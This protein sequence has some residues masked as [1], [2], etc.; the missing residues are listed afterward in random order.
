MII[1]QELHNRVM[2]KVSATVSKYFGPTFDL[3]IPVSYRSDMKGTAGI[4]YV[5]SKK[6]ELNAQLFLANTEKFFERTIPHEVAHIITKMV[7]PHAKQSHG[8]EW[9]SVMDHIGVD[10]TRCHTYDVSALVKRMERF[11]Y[12]CACSRPLNITKIMHNKIQK[13]S[14]RTCMTCNTV[15]YYNP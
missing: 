13:G 2:Q 4:A 6:I 3:D 15:V 7:H 12:A 8:P 10:S 1:T 9:R 11:T 5:N 14:V